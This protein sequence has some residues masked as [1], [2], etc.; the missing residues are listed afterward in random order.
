MESYILTLGLSI[1]LC[2]ALIP[3]ARMLA[4]RIGLVDQPDGRRKI[5]GRTVPVAGGLAVFAT[6][7]LVLAAAFY[8]PHPLQDALV[9]QAPLLFGLFVASAI[10]VATGVA[11]DLG[12]LRGRHKL[13]G[14]VAAIL[15]L[16]RCGVY[17]EHVQV[18]GATIELGLLGGL[19]TC[20]FLLGAI[21]SVNLIDG[22]DGLLGC[23]GWWL[24]VTLACLAALAGQ[25]WAALIAL[26]LAGA[27]FAFL[28]YNLPPASVFM[29][30]AG[31]MLVGLVVGTLAIQCSLKAP[32]SVAILLPI[33]LLA[34]PFFDTT[35]AIVRRK[36]TGRSI[37]T[38]DRGH[39]HHCLQR[40]GL[41]TRLVLV[42]VSLCCLVT[43]GGVLASQAF[44]N[45][46]IVLLT[47]ASVVCTLVRT[48]LFGHAEVMLIKERALSLLQPHSPAR[49][50]EV[51]LQGSSNWRPLWKV[52][53]D[54]AQRLQLQEMMLDVNAPALH[55]GYHARWDRAAATDEVS[56]L[57]RMSIPLAAG[58]QAIGRLE[59]AGQ[60]DQ[61][62]I[63]V[64]I[65]ELTHVIEMHTQ[66][67]ALSA[68]MPA[69]AA[70]AVEACNL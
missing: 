15:V 4:L 48:R 18:F 49:Q 40:R 32:A 9:E 24:S 25:S 68:V 20:A 16:I 7:W 2:L 56:T 59:I 29:G 63:W 39:L 64:K 53:T 35:A 37:Y 41:S 58:G 66:P 69:A 50:M 70:P 67:A 55:E 1:M 57:W 31:S 14:Q 43:C 8:L 30:D 23:I 28:R 44:D 19:F 33:G 51:R 17:V 47:I 42:V 13:V 3:A 38:T 26:A 60:P 61:E 21:N 34:L 36:L 65:A 54:T 5:H 46:L 11:D 6:V 52:L 62:P 45:E 12:W 27:L 22:M 10:I